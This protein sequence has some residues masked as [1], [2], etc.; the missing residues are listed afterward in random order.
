MQCEYEVDILIEQVSARQ[1]RNPKYDI[2]GT[3]EKADKSI[4]PH[5]LHE[6]SI[7]ALFRAQG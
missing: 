4:N 6:L 5:R 3:V 7:Q 2:I 1:P